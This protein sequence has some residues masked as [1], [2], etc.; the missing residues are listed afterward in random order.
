METTL[1]LIGIAVIAFLLWEIKKAVDQPE[2][3]VAPRI[4]M[5]TGTRAP[6]FL[7]YHAHGDRLP[8]MN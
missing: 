8:L 1:I 3:T 4:A 5:Q 7:R 2:S 6:P